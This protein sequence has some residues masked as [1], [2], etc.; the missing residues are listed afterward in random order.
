MS[1]WTEQTESQKSLKRC[2]RQ[3]RINCN[4]SVVLLIFFILKYFAYNWHF[5]S[6]IYDMSAVIIQ[7]NVLNKI[8]YS[9]DTHSIKP[10]LYER[11]EQQKKRLW[12][13]FIQHIFLVDTNVIKYKTYLFKM[14]YDFMSYKIIRQKWRKVRQ[15]TDRKLYID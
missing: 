8:R 2:F 12:Y 13:G 10:L 4:T 5:D 1:W 9:L 15:K 3:S 14:M 7:L 6:N 11:N